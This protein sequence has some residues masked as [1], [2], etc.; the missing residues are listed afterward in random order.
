MTIDLDAL[1]HKSLDE[2][3]A[4]NLP[5][6]TPEEAGLEIG[7]ESKPEY[8]E[9]IREYFSHFAVPEKGGDGFVSG[10]PC[11]CCGKP[12]GGFLGFF[13]WGLAHGHGACSNCGWPATVYHFIRDKNGEELCTL[14]GLLLQAHPNDVEKRK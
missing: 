14:R 11:L 5:R 7:A 12:Q 3:Q 6:C 8:V 2:L 13:Q 1:D 4:A 10:S 9:A